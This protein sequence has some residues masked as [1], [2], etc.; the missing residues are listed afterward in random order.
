MSNSPFVENAT[1]SVDIVS[2][3]VSLG[4][5]VD[6]PL[7]CVVSSSYSVSEDE[8]F[9]VD[10]SSTVSDSGTIESSLQIQRTTTDRSSFIT[11]QK[12]F[13][14]PVV[15]IKYMSFLREV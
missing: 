4:P 2:S 3:T 12:L 8:K 14:F 9:V 1:L 6:S 15:Q 11:E 7:L 13:S 5:E 10:S